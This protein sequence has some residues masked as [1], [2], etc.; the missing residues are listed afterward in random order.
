M[1]STYLM[2][3]FTSTM[4]F[5]TYE[6]IKSLS[7]IF[8]LYGFEALELPPSPTKMLS[9]GTSSVLAAL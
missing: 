4:V 7:C 2:Y 3:G 8:V 9:L 5:K 6:W 1:V